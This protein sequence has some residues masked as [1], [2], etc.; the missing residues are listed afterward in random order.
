MVASHVGPTGRS[1]GELELGLCGLVA[2]AW[3]DEV[4]RAL[5]ESSSSS[6]RR[7]GWTC[8][9]HVRQCVRQLNRSDE[10]FNTRFSCVRIFEVWSFCLLLGGV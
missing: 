2:H 9:V 8:I 1:K 10:S 4:N 6:A 7:R 5:N 3:G